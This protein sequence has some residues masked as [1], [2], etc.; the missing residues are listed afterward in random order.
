M[1]TRTGRRI[2]IV[3]ILVVGIVVMSVGV[4]SRRAIVEQW[5]ISR[6]GS[7]D[8][9]TRLHAA[10]RLAELRSVRAVP[11]LL[12]L[13]EKDD[14]ENVETGGGLSFWSGPPSSKPTQWPEEWIALTPLAYAIYEIGRSASP[15]VTKA[16][17]EDVGDERFRL[18]L[19]MLHAAISADESVMVKL[20]R[21]DVVGDA[22]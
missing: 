13:I 8:E 18:I 12:E 20:T 14:R 21:Y 15:A 2:A 5:Y 9:A 22:P 1:G 6:L 10:N 17:Q 11:H 4:A 3:T 16:Q 19:W 7:D